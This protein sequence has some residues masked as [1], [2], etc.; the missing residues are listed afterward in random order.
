MYH[1]GGFG[2]DTRGCLSLWRQTFT[3]IKHS[4]ATLAAS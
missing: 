3:R 2:T 4:W 1:F